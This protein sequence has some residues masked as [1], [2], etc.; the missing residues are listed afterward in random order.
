MSVNRNHELW[1]NFGAL[2]SLGKIGWDKE[3]P[4]QLNLF[5]L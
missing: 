1:T 4:K 5:E 2:K 3:P